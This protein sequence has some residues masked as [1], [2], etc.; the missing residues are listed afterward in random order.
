[1]ASNL[2]CALCGAEVIQEGAYLKCQNPG[3]RS[4]TPIDTAAIN[5]AISMDKFEALDEASNA[6]E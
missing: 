1:M 3:C 6:T 4:E 5:T 2:T